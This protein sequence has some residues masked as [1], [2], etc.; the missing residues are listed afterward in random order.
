MPILSQKIYPPLYHTAAE[1]ETI[2]ATEGLSLWEIAIRYE[3]ARGGITPAE[4]LAKMDRLVSIM[5]HTIAKV[6]RAPKDFP[7]RILG[8]QAH[9]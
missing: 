3:A 1:I 6:S 5:E 2:A 4:V 7:N 8:P 9:R